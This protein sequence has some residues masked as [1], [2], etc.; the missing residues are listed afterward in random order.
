ME[1]EVKREEVEKLNRRL[2]AEAEA[3]GYHLN[4]DLDTTMSVIGGLAK[5]KKRYGYMLCPCRLTGDSRVKDL[6]IICPC[7]YRDLDMGEYN[8]CYCGLYVTKRVIDGVAQVGDVPER[9]PPEEE[10][11]SATQ[12]SEDRG[13][14]KVWRCKVCGYLCAREDPP[15]VCPICKATKDRFVTFSFT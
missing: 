14:V 3:S 4:P 11:E 9:R 1:I 6:D 2:N 12:T 7:D 5:N 10:R 13:G 15:D 8:S